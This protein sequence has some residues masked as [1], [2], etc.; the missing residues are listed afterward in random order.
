MDTLDYV[1]KKIPNG[2]IIK[3]GAGTNFLHCY[4]RNELTEKRLENESIDYL[5]NLKRL[6]RQNEYMRDTSDERLNDTLSKTP[7]DEH[8]EIRH[9]YDIELKK[10]KSRIAKMKA[11]I[12]YF[13][14]FLER[15]VV[16]VYESDD[17]IEPNTTIIIIK[18]SDSGSYWNIDEYAI[19]KKLFVA[20]KDRHKEYKKE[21]EKLDK[22]E[23]K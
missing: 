16:N 21:W 20:K 19:D 23:K 6:L 22:G 1:L 14:P 10:T 3:I 4:Y 5:T 15:K 12:H 2:K 13:K 18:G 7:L 11:A 9:K 17:C 8:D